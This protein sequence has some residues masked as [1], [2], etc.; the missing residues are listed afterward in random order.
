MS[1]GMRKKEI[2]LSG[3]IYHLIFTMY[4]NIADSIDSRYIRTIER[5][6]RTIEVMTSN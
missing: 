6:G 5:A 2:A 1:R 3:C 4:Y